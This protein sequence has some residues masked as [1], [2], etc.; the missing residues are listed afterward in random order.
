MT[1]VINQKITDHYAM[2]HSDSVIAMDGIPSDSVGLCV[3]SPPFPGMYVYTNSPHDM[4][5][6]SS[7]GQMINQ[8][9]F[10]M[11]ADKLFRVMMPGRSVFV[12]ITQGVAQ[13]GRDGYIGM[14]DFRGPII[15]MMESHGW[16][17]Y[18]EI[19][20][21]K[22]P[23]L[24]A[25]RTKDHGL[26]FKSLV[27]DSARMH[28]AMPDILL[29]FRKP[30]D[31]PK[32]IRAGAVDRYKDD[33]NAGWV[34]N[35]EWI[36]W[37]RPIWYAADYMPGTWRPDHNGDPYPDGI[38][39]TDVLNV[40]QARETNDERHLCPLQ[41]GVI[42]RC[43]KVWSAPG[44]VV[45]D[46][47]TGIGSTGYVALQLGRKFIGSELKESYFRHACRNLD[48]VVAQQDQPTLFDLAV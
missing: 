45:L 4:G 23:Q 17:Y 37:A 38:R 42:E 11:A 27:S 10:L 21:D 46:P 43:V 26:M 6:V 18:G 20:I 33:D 8:F 32:P 36:N 25:M 39:E 34:S 15:A 3:F 48:N 44:D 7:I 16:I 40:H 29:Q 22:D 14:K 2:Y 12:H 41:L 47:F 9:S 30:G 13:K 1:K 24:K 19:T 35:F 5:N 28:T 31:N